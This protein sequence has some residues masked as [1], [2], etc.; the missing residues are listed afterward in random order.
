MTWLK[1]SNTHLNKSEQDNSKSDKSAL[2]C[3]VTI[4]SFWRHNNGIMYK[5]IALANTR[6]ERPK[7]YPIMVVYENIH[8]QAVWCRKLSDWHRSMTSMSDYLD[9]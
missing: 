4:G 2:L 5:V 3:D 6:T 9:T 8:N 7:D 1:D